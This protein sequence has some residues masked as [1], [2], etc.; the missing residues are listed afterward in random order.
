MTKYLLFIVA[1]LLIATSAFAIK[2]PNAL[3]SSR[4]GSEQINI[5]QLPQIT[6]EAT[7]IDLQTDTN[8][9]CENVC[10]PYEYPLDTATIR[11]DKIIAKSNPGQL[12]LD[13]FYEGAQIAVSFGYSARPAKVRTIISL[14]EVKDGEGING[15]VS[16]TIHPD[17]FKPIPKEDGYYIF[18]IEADSEQPEI[19][20]PG[21]TVGSRFRATFTASYGLSQL[22]LGEYDIL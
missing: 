21:L 18:S 3:S 17:T 14:P 12:S 9:A 10:T 22:R 16:H 7:V 8:T 2:R 15:T 11:L 13:S 5:L 19:T 4:L 6:A 1:L 20:L